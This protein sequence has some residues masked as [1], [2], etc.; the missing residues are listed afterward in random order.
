M[1]SA[2]NTGKEALSVSVTASAEAEQRD[3][4][5]VPFGGSTDRQTPPLVTGDKRHD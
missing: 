1:P 2:V 3:R 4:P 5:L